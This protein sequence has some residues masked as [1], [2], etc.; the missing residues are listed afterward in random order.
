MA[1][2]VLE[3]ELT[4][5]HL[6]QVSCASTEHSWDASQL[7]SLG[8]KSPGKRFPYKTVNLVVQETTVLPAVV[9]LSKDLHFWGVQFKAPS[10]G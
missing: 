10:H 4:K 2:G 1:L 8:W 6:G 5:S 3:Q 7:C 9:M